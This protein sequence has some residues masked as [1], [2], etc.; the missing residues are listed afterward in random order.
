MIF[1]Q[2]K[3]L[4]NCIIVIIIIIKLCP[5]LKPLRQVGLI[6]ICIQI[7][8]VP[9]KCIHIKN[10]CK[11]SVFKFYY[12]KCVKIFTNNNLLFFLQRFDHILNNSVYF[13]QDKAP[14]HYHGDVRSFL[15][16]LLPNRWIGQKGFVEYPTH[17]PNL[18]LLDFLWGYLKDKVYATKPATVANLK[19][20]IEHECAHI[21]R[22]L[23]HG[24]CNSV[25][26]HFQQ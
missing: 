23:F 5:Y 26:W 9:E 3:T 25:A 21:L 10:N 16:K 14:P 15:D 8:G 24:V 7:Q 1:C 12:F 17:S 20:A 11:R 22:E 13:Q 4:C 6:H 19:E 2:E 18:T